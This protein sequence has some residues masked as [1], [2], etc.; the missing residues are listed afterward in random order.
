MTIARI[1][2]KLDER[3]FR[4]FDIHTSDGK[5]VTVKAPDFVWVHPSGR[6]MYVCP[7]PNVDAD[8]VIDL[9]QVTKLTSGR[10]QRGKRNGK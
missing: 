4:P 2:A 1:R 7:N 10:Q 8:E 3:P 6:T 9:R 5:T